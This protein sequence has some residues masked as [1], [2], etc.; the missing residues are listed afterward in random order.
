MVRLRD[1]EMIGIEEFVIYSF[2]EEGT[3]HTMQGHMGEAPGFAGRK[4]R[5]PGRGQGKQA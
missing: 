2:Q 3:H 1:Q 5:W 4:G